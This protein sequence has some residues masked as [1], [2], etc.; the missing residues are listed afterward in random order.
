MFAWFRSFVSAITFA[1]LAGFSSEAVPQTTRPSAEDLEFFEREIRPLLA[2]QCYSCHSSQIETPFAG[3]RVDSR[4]ALLKGGE[5]GAAILP[6]DPEKSRLIKLLRGEPLL[7]PPTGRLA[8]DRIAALGKWIELGAPWPED[9]PAP[10]PQAGDFD[11]EARKSSHW[12]WQP[13]AVVEP[14]AVSDKDWPAGPGDRF[15]LAKLDEEGLKP[16]SPADR[17]TLIRRLSFDLTGLPPT[18]EQIRA[19]VQD[20]SPDAYLKLVRRLLDSPH[21]GERWARHWMDLVRYA[22][23]HG[24]EGDPEIPVAWRY[25]NYLIRALNNDVPYDQL[26][27][28][29]LAGD[30]LENPRINERDGINESILGTAHYRMIEHGYQPVDPW[31]DRVKVRGQPD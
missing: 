27:R 12:A 15:L 30:L 29:H 18:P 10:E 11:L 6:G 13:V 7:M 9:E 23:S 21:F 1:F 24:S 17:Y 16:A 26:I 28:E 14:P 19:F 8:E 4:E 20:N 3:L 22:E 31:E 5:S 2:E 25:R